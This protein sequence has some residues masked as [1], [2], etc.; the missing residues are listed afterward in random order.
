MLRILLIVIFGVTF[1][2]SAHAQYT[3]QCVPAS[4]PREEIPMHFGCENDTLPY[5]KKLACTKQGPPNYFG[6]MVLYQKRFYEEFPQSKAYVDEWEQLLRKCDGPFCVKRVLRDQQLQIS[7]AFAEGGMKP[8]EIQYWLPREQ[9][10]FEKVYCDF[11]KYRNLIP[12]E[13][14]LRLYEELDKAERFIERDSMDL[15]I[16]I[17]N[18][19]AIDSG[20]PEAQNLLAKLYLDG[21]VQS[22]MRFPGTEKNASDTQIAKDLLQ[23]AVKSGHEPS[24]SLLRNVMLDNLVYKNQVDKMHSLEVRLETE[25]EQNPRCAFESIWDFLDVS[26]DQNISLAELAKFQRML[27]TVAYSAN[28][29]DVELEEILGVQSMTVMLFPM[30]SKAIISSYDY[31]DDGVLSRDEV[32]GD[33]DL[34]ELLGFTRQSISSDLDFKS[35]GQRL[36]SQTMNSSIMNLLK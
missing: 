31:N 13:D 21:K 17:L 12:G 35:L 15:A 10:E 14:I 26:G 29:D 36:L 32:L 1:A 11:L 7:N 4:Y 19:L 27:V 16:D 23:Q 25:C 34:A 8:E 30:I 9:A 18:D 24:K 22:K 33:T 6:L 2:A 28:Q 3:L 20:V 5:Y